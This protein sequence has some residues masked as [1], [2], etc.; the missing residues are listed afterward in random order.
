MAAP[1]NRV[2]RSQLIK[3]AE[4]L[5]DKVARSSRDTHYSATREKVIGQIAEETAK[6]VR[7]T[8]GEVVEDVE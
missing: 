3:D 8:G 6:L 7:A 2:P 1:G 5:A 4:A